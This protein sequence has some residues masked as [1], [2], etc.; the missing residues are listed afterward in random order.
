MLLFLALL[1]SWGQVLAAPFMP[2]HH[3]LA[4]SS[5]QHVAHQHAGHAAA[6]LAHGHSET[7]AGIDCDPGC[8]LQCLTLVLLALPAFSFLAADVASVVH[9]RTLDPFPPAQP[10]AAHF[11]PPQ[12]A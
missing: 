4:G 1:L 8:R 5:V 10:L 3:E 2:C 9:G 6:V 11:R 12:A 7:D